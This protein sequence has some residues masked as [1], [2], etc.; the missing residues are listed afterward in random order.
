LER[1]REGQETHLRIV[2]FHQQTCC[3][4]ECLRE[5]GEARQS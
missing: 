4:A 3:I 2:V 1:G 5:K